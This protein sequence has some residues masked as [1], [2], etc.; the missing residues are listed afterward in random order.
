M[1]GERGRGPRDKKKKS[2]WA[3]LSLLG[4]SS[5]SG[6]VVFSLSCGRVDKPRLLPLVFSLRTRW[7]EKGILGFWSRSFLFPGESSGAR[8]G[9]SSRTLVVSFHRAVI[10]DSRVG[11]TSRRSSTTTECEWAP[12][13]API[14]PRLG[15]NER[16]Y[17][18]DATGKFLFLFLWVYV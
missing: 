10:V 13:R 1:G 14:L 9:P 15:P 11:H 8:G 7:T 3:V 5:L 4:W 16:P 6:R 17:R 12:G 2:T 18:D